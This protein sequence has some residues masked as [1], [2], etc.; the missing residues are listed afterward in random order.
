MTLG[1]VFRA[2]DD[3]DEVFDGS[4]ESFRLGDLIALG[5]QAVQGFPDDL[6]LAA[7]AAAGEPPQQCFGFGIQS[8]ARGYDR[9]PVLQECSTG[10]AAGQSGLLLGIARNASGRK[11][12]A[13]QSA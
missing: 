3:T 1:E 11:S 13:A 7:S 4:I 9:A 12:R 8:D 2:V 10:A 5:G 6:R